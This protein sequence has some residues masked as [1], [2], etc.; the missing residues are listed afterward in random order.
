MKSRYYALGISWIVLSI[1]ILGATA[2]A[3]RNIAYPEGEKYAPQYDKEY[4][5]YFEEESFD[6]T[7]HEKKRVFTIG[8]ATWTITE[9]IKGEDKI[10]TEIDD[11][12]IGIETSPFSVCHFMDWC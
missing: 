3:E 1:L 10:K 2:H 6:Y 11:I 4:E 8:T 12:V 7:P 9:S 5:D